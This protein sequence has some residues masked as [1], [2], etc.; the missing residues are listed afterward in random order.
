MCDAFVIVSLGYGFVS[1][2]SSSN[3]I[4]LNKLKTAT[5]DFHFYNKKTIKNKII[6]Y[7]SD[8]LKIQN[9]KIL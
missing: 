6:K 8:S 9:Y 4:H 1:V 7:N 3:Y 2:G 5:I